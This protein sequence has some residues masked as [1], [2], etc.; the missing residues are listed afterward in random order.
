LRI[1]VVINFSQ[2]SGDLV[3]LLP[4][5]K[6]IILLFLV[7]YYM[8]II[9]EYLK[10]KCVCVYE[11]GHA[12]THARV[13]AHT[14]CTYVLIYIFMLCLLQRRS[15]QSNKTRGYFLKFLPV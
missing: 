3:R 4:G 14:Y 10:N 8:W 11:R 15:Q 5:L 6:W 9:I 1:S 12:C 13:R 7:F 2:R